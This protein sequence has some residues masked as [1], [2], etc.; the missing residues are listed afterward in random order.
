MV[1]IHLPGIGIIA[2][3]WYMLVLVP[4][5]CFGVIVLLFWLVRRLFEN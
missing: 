2:I 3:P 4:C 5:L 1:V